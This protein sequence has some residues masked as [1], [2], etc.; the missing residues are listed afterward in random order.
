MLWGLWAFHL[1][2]SELTE[3]L[4]LG[5]R[6]VRIAQE[7]DDA[8][9]RLVALPTVGQAHYFRG[10][11]EAARRHLDR[12][13]DLDDS[14]RDRP[15]ASATG[16]DTEVVVLACRAFVLWHFGEGSAAVRSSD[17]AVVLAECI[18]HP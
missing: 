6:L 15:V 5:R 7:A 13:V 14:G 12:A 3:A 9:L 16:Q 4:D 8:D 10:E 2:R 17:E 11:L 1:V 18:G